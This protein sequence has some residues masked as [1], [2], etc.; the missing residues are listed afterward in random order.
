MPQTFLPHRAEDFLQRWF[1]A[2]EQLT[3]QESASILAGTTV[4]CFTQ[5]LRISLPPDEFGQLTAEQIEEAHEAMCDRLFVKSSGVVQQSVYFPIS[6][7]PIEHFCATVLL[8]PLHE[9]T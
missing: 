1:V 8:P 5:H 4:E 7:R 6:V 3:P 9:S 2:L